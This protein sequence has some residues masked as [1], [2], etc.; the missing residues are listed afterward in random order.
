MSGCQPPEIGVASIGFGRRERQ[1]PFGIV[2]RHPQPFVQGC[3]DRPVGAGRIHSLR[4]F[5]L[6]PQPQPGKAD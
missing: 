5:P 1:H 6:A 4:V 2:D 3:L